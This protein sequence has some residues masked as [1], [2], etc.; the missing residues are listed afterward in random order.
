M[1]RLAVPV[2]AEATDA[3]KG[4]Y[5]LC[6]RAG[7]PAQQW[8]AYLVCGPQPATCPTL[9]RIAGSCWRIESAFEMARQEVGLDENKVHND[10]GWDHHMILTLLSVG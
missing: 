8:Q 3:T 4:Y 5:L 7:A 1:V 9:I 10:R 2:L 6:R